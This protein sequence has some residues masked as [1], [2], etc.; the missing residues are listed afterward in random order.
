MMTAS[1]G[2][3][4][5]LTYPSPLLSPSVPCGHASTFCYCNACLFISPSSLLHFMYIISYLFSICAILTKEIAEIILKAVLRFNDV[6]DMI[7]TASNRDA[8][9]GI[10]VK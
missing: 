1:I 9:N 2:I 4:D 6:I 7:M 5:A 8:W 10:A 3:T